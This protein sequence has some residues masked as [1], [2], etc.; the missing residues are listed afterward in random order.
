MLDAGR[1]TPNT[2]RPTVSGIDPAGRSERTRR[3]LYVDRVAID[4]T[5]SRAASETAA[6]VVVSYPGNLSDWGRDQINGSRFRTYLRRTKTRDDLEPGAIWEEFVDTGCCGDTLD[7][8]LRVEAVDGPPVMGPETEI[9]YTERE[10]DTVEGGW[11]VQSA[12]G[13]TE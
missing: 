12:A 9:A 3:H 5:D 4:M 7:V 1:R 2:G 13:P 11:L 8:P 6:R 10:D